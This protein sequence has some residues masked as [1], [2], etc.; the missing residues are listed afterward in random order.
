MKAAIIGDVH[1][2]RYGQDADNDSGGSEKLKS[3][4]ASLYE[5]ANYCKAKKIP[6]IIFT[7]D[8]FHNKS[9]LYA[10]AQDI[11][12]NFLNDF[13][14]LLF[15]II[16][17]NH[18]L[19]GKVGKVVSSLKGIQG[20]KNVTWITATDGKLFWQHPTENM[21]FVPYS[22]F[23]VDVIKSN[24]SDIL[25]SHFGL[26]EGML[27]SGISIKTNI[28]INDLKGKYKHV[29]LGHYHKPQEY[30]DS[31]IQ[32]YYIGSIIQLDWGEKEDVK[33]FLVIDTKDMKIFS[34]PINS[35]KKH[36][37]VEVTKENQKEAIALALKAKDNGDHVK[38]VIKENIE[39]PK[40]LGVSIIDKYERDITNRGITANMNQNERL[41]RY[42]MIR[43]IKEEQHD[44]LIK[45]ANE[46][47][48]ACTEEQH[49]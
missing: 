30:R 31:D 39:L 18:D 25:I 5:I 45:L 32:V 3:I 23:M 16:D 10:V 49:P 1:L 14:D 33:R 26:N 13:P 22:E 19:S 4:Q 28:S 40:D 21:L 15:Y 36:I 8:I 43:D 46:V 38:I 41:K 44:K 9:I 7:G 11:F 42:L 2:S 35:Y 47:I 17:G 29:L 27:N 6:N 48:D 37:E 12:I 24:K 34:I 20:R